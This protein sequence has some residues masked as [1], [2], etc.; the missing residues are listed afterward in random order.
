[1]KASL[2]RTN[3]VDIVSLGES[4]YIH[5]PETLQKQLLDIKRWFIGKRNFMPFGSPPKYQRVV[6]SSHGVPQVQNFLS[7]FND[8]CIQISKLLVEKSGKKVELVGFNGQPIL[9]LHA[10]RLQ[11]GVI[12]DRAL[13]P[14]LSKALSCHVIDKFTSLD[15]AEEV[16][17]D[18][19]SLE[20][21]AED[22]NTMFKQFPRIA[23]YYQALAQWAFN[24]GKLASM[25]IAVVYLGKSITVTRLTNNSEPFTF[26]AGPGSV[27]VDEIIQ[28]NFQKNGDPYGIMAQ[29]GEVVGQLIKSW[30]KHPFF[31]KTDF[32]PFKSG[33]F[34][35]CIEECVGSL[36]PL[37]S[38]ATLTSFSAQ[39][40]IE[41][42]SRRCTRDI[43]LLGPQSE[44]AII[45]AMLGRYFRVIPAES[46]EWR[47]DFI[48]SG[49]Y[50]YYAA[51]THSLTPSQ[52]EKN[53]YLAVAL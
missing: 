13:L 36:S 26:D 15:N 12:Y 34:S 49:Q 53:N 30:M 1:M 32:P 5:Y 2:L 31:Q 44:N 4:S 9:F 6:L 51:R 23:Q 46:L 35:S 18:N 22:P 52:R 14:R 28:R 17:L 45:T 20:K 48:E 3:G 16:E 40:L 42:L 11:E 47:C 7:D 25:D 29:K 43:I 41:Q 21:E 24:R 19:S 37:D 10:N 8:W 50:A 33:D 38:I 39:V 27:F